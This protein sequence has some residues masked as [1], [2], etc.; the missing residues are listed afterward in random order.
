[1]GGVEVSN[2]EIPVTG[3][4]KLCRDAGSASGF[5]RS[6]RP[7]ALQRHRAIYPKISKP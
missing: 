6:Q 7:G 1:M 3:N 2:F 4:R 5:F